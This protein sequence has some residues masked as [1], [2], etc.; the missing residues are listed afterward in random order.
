MT[1]HF[2]GLPPLQGHLDETVPEAI[3]QPTGVFLEHIL[4]GGPADIEHPRFI[5]RFLDAGLPGDAY[6][7]YRERMLKLIAP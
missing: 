3:R 7:E 1:N 4:E 2:L 6:V 5:Q